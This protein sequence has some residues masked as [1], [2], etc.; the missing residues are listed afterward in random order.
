MDRLTEAGD[1]GQI[2]KEIG[3]NGNLIHATEDGWILRPDDIVVQEAGDDGNT[4]AVKAV[5]AF[6]NIEKG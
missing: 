2:V 3:E 4:V 1:E 6:G 5:K